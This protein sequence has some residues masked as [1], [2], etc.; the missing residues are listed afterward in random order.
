MSEL[1]RAERIVALEVQVAHLVDANK[2]LTEKV[3]LLLDKL[4]QARGA[5][6]LLLVLSGVVGFVGGKLGAAASWFK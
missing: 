3:Q 6:W 1:E 5:W 4:N 2:A